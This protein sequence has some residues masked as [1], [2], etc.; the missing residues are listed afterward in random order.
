M[1]LLD[2]V[3]AQPLFPE[4]RLP[5][6][7]ADFRRLKDSNPDGYEANVT[8]WKRVLTQA[9][10][11]GG[12]TYWKGAVTRGP[13][14]GV[15]KTGGIDDVLIIHSGR[16]LL[17]SLTS[18]EWGKPL[19][20]SAVFEEEVARRAFVP[21]DTFLNQKY[22]IYK[23][24]SWRVV[25]YGTSV[26]GWMLRD[27]FINEYYQ[28]VTSW[29]KRDGQLPEIDFVILEN[30]VEAAK[31]LLLRVRKA[32]KAG[33]SVSAEK[34]AGVFT[35][36]MLKDLYCRDPFGV[37]ETEGVNA[38]KVKG[39][40]PSLTDLDFTILIRHITR[41]LQQATVEGNIIKFKE[42]SESLAPITEE[43][44]AVAELRH[45]IMTLSKRITSQ[46]LHAAASRQKAAE[47]ATKSPITD[48]LRSLARN[49]LKKAK[50]A[51]LSMQKSMDYKLQMES[52]LEN[53]ENAHSNLEITKIMESSLPVLEQLNKRTGGIEKVSDLADK[54]REQR[55]ETEEIGRAIGEVS[56]DEVDED[57][58][59]HEFDRLLQ[60][61]TKPDNTNL[62]SKPT[63]DDLAALLS[64]ASLDE[65]PS[66]ERVQKAER[67]Q[68]FT[69]A[70]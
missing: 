7:F 52:L 59:E 58:I 51:E 63:E 34:F 38:D 15:D 62:E 35:V 16:K 49:E 12:P 9:V 24:S 56:A 18:R 36:D 10:R 13:D 11:E 3:L 2:Y 50:S 57:E 55:A 70:T 6:L 43:D 29:R 67:E 28:S 41:D 69:E 31:I 30:L 32:R 45:M 66:L 26:L 20:L 39:N 65:V 37:A 64:K 33:V 23:D 17:D 53:I 25:K 27:S 5:S 54:L 4:R 22:N 8:A 61:E 21:V 48:H 60:D 47:Y 14:E 46:Q 42:A 19:G 1:D 40:L 68:A 44:K